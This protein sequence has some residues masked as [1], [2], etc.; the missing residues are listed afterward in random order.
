[1]CARAG[2]RWAGVGLGWRY[3]AVPAALAG[4]IAIPVGTVKATDDGT[5]IYE[6]ET[7]LQYARVVEQ[8][9]GDRA[10]EL[11]E[12]QA[13]H[14]LYRPGSYLTGDVWDGSLVLPFAGLQRAP[15]RIAI[16]GKGAGTRG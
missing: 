1:A 3:F 11:N 9:D 15:E 8:E 4:A 7:E 13:V 12:G 5:V 2:G 16:L 6:T 14:S 10:L